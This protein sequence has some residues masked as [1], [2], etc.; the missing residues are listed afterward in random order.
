MLPAVDIPRY[1]RVNTL[2]RSIK[3]VI[4]IFQAE[5]WQ[6]E[7]TP[8][9]YLAFLQS[10]SNLPEDHFIQDLHMKEL[11]IFPK[12]TEF[13]YHHLYQD[14]SIFLQNKSSLLPVYL[15]D[16]CPNSVVLDM[17]AAPGMKTTHIAAKIKN[18]G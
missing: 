9:S 11:L 4:E 1:V 2:I 3:D 5:G 7:V 6:L 14:G 12:R 13:F 17:C 16:P 8:D 18:K 15:L 10:V